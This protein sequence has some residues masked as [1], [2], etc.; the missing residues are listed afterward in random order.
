MSFPR[1]LRWS[2]LLLLPALALPVQ[3]Q[4]AAT[5]P[6]VAD[7]LRSPLIQAPALNPSGTYAAALFTGGE[8]TYQLMIKEIGSEAKAVFVGGAGPVQVTQFWWLDDTHIAYTLSSLGSGQVGLMVV[9]VHAPAEAYPVWQYGVAQ[10]VGVPAESPMKPLV[11]VSVA[12]AD[13]QPGVIELDASL[14]DGG[15]VDLKGGDDE[16]AWT[17][18]A[19][20]N[21]DHVL[22]VVPVPAGKTQVGYVCD[23]EGNLAFATTTDGERVTLHVWD[24]TTW[25]ESGLDLTTLEIV[26]VGQ[27]PGELLV[28]LP[29]KEGEPAGLYFLN[30]LTGEVGDL[31]LRDPNYDFNGS[32][33]RD[34][35][36]H[37][38][39]GAFYDR[40]GPMTSWFNEAYQKL[41]GVLNAFFPG[42]FVRLMGGNPAGTMMLAAVSSDRDPVA[43]YTI[44][45]EARTVGLLASERPWIDAAQ[46]RQTSVIK[47]RTADGKKLDAYVTVPAG[48]TPETKVP[49]V[50]LPH[51]G[52]WMRNSWG[53]DPE[54]QILA[55]RGYAVLQLNYR[56]STGY[57]ALFTEAERADFQMMRVDVS[58][59]VKTVLRTGL[60]DA[61]RIAISGGGF[62]GYLA[63]ASLV[64]EPDLYACGVTFA[65]IYD[66]ARAAN[67]LGLER[68]QDAN[69]GEIFAALGDPGRDGAKFRAISPTSQLGRLKAPLLV[70]EQPGADGVEQLEA[71]K[72]I[73]ALRDAGKPVESLNLDGGL[74]TLESRVKLFEGIEAFLAK[75]L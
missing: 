47:Y 7:F 12:S 63:V 10:V 6:P 46:M 62:G 40:A 59:A 55:S 14:N 61:D 3:A 5:P 17:E 29:A 18:V 37:T 65:G 56:G 30:A 38:V 75:H 54:V 32:V 42:K 9:D 20:R 50:V 25:L 31:V 2:L 70:I 45:L 68:N 66:W 26:D 53:F 73:S 64:E 67:E 1:I 23:A 35:A 48:A 15:F 21:S 34:P 4:D 52:P 16:E 36:S 33:Y 11:W 72:L 44:N 13:A 57:D 19:K 58:R 74:A 60:I 22:R 28:R 41:Q 39:V 8:E 24:G 69:Y 43:Y 49:L 51:G 71:T 27:E